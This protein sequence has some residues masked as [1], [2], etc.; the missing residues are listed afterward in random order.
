MKVNN[1]QPMSECEEISP[2]MYRVNMRT[3]DGLL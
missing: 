1:A 3:E 2:S